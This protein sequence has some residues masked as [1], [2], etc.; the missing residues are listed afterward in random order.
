VSAAPRRGTVA[1]YRVALCRYC[2]LSIR[3][4]GDGWRHDKT[5]YTACAQEIIGGE[6]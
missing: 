5:K 4:F 3:N 6:S 2:G 1:V